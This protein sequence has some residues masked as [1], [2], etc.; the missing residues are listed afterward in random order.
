MVSKT[1][2]SLAASLAAV[3]RAPSRKRCW[4]GTLLTELDPADRTALQEVLDARDVTATAV[5]QALRA[6]G[7]DIRP[8]NVQ[9]HRRRE[10]ACP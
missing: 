5:S 10:C 7:H 8:Y 4:I 1:S 9:R 6:H 2:G 3:P